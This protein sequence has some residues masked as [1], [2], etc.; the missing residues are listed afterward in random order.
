MVMKGIDSHCHL[1]FE[2][3]DNDRREIIR[4]SKKNLEFVVNPGANPE[5]NKKAFELHKQ[6]PDFIKFNTGLHPVY[7]GDFNS[8]N[9]V[10]EQVRNFEPCAIGEIG[11]D[12]HHV[13]EP[14]LR[15]KQEAVFRE[16]LKLAENLDKPIV[17][18]SR[19]AEQKAVNI[20]SEYDVDRVFLHCFN[21]SRDI[22]DKAVKNGWTIGVTTQVLY[23]SKVQKLVNHLDLNNIVLETDSPYLY[24]GD[25][26][27][28]LNILES[29]KKIAEINDTDKKR[30]LNITSK[31]SR[32]LFVS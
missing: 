23:S 17:V 31:N 22:A 21:G 11:L 9:R 18:H 4:E 1:D 25:R 28:P 15:E 8:L 20:I 7:T 27:E 24:R 13:K 14:N 26:N 29:A 3:F 30:V 12:H 10:K 16:M 2:Q 32:N 19:N 5:H 6:H